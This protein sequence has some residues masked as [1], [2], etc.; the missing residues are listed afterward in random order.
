MMQAARDLELD[1]ITLFTQRGLYVRRLVDAVIGEGEG[2]GSGARDQAQ[3]AARFLVDRQLEIAQGETMFKTRSEMLMDRV[4]TE[5][6][7]RDLEIM[8]YQVRRLAKKLALAAQRR[9]R[10]DIRGVPNIARSL[11]ANLKHDGQMFDLI[12]KQKKITRPRI[13]ALCDVS[14]SVSNAVKFLLMFLYNLTEVVS[15]VRAFAFSNRLGEVSALFKESEF[16]EAYQQTQRQ[17][18]GGSTDYG[19]S[20][21]DFDR[22]AGTSI[23]RKTIIIILGDARSNYGECGA[24]VLERLGQFAGRVLWL[25]PEGK[26]LWGSG[27]SEMPRLGAL[28]H[29]AHPCQT[30]RQLTH[31]IDDVLKVRV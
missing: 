1:K 9:T 20:L 14:G 16:A 3:E 13:F 23:D 5:A 24:E 7:Q 30:L 26:N 27:D 29:E 6:D 18:G 19:A 11:R 17:F 21:A 10:K 8:S 12:W 2:A 22:L 25:N 15:G 31:I 28:C 4:F